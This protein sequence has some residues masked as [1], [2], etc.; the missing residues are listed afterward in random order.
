MYQKTFL[1][2]LFFRHAC[3][4]ESISQVENFQDLGIYIQEPREESQSRIAINFYHTSRLQ[5]QRI[6]KDPEIGALKYSE[7]S[8]K[9]QEPYRNLIL[10]GSD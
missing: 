4:L 9:M 8:P 6:Y 7:I 5:N 2:C 1:W 10:Q 3:Y